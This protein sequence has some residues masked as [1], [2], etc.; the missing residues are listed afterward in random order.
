MKYIISNHIIIYGT[1][2]YIGLEH[3]VEFCD[4]NHN[5]PKLCVVQYFHLLLLR[6]HIIMK[7]ESYVN[8]FLRI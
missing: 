5:Y 4:Q 6:T 3:C 8:S 2:S 1:I 7:L